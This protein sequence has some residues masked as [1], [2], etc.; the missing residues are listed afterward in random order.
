LRLR[1]TVADRPLV[2]QQHESIEDIRLQVRN[3][4][5]YLDEERREDVKNGAR[6]CIVVGS[7]RR[8]SLQAK[9]GLEVE[10]MFAAASTRNPSASTEYN[11]TNVER[12]FDEE[13]WEMQPW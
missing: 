9:A 1:A 7:D 13:E 6:C 2:L 4:L 11:R 12:T 5:L 10:A 8:G 3:D